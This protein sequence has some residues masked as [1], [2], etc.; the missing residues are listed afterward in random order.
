M[1]H[2]GGSIMLPGFCTLVE[3]GKLIRV[4]SK[5]DKAMYRET[6]DENMR[7]GAQFSRFEWWFMVY[8][9]I[10]L[11]HTHRSMIE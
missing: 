11:K 2:G 4:D 9:V 8:R 5:I 3:T 10:T 1:K 6:V 7:E